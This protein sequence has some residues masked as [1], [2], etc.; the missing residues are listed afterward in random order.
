MTERGIGIAVAKGWL[1]VASRDAARVQ[2][3]ANAAAGVA[4]LVAPVQALAP[5]AVVLEATGGHERLVATA[6]DAADIPVA[7]VNPLRGR[8]FA[9]STGTL[10]KTAA[11]DARMLALLGTRMQ[12]DP[13][14]R[15]DE[16]S[17]ELAAW[18]ARRRQ[19]GDLQS[20]ERNRRSSVAP[21]RRS[22]V[23]AHRAGLA[24]Q[25]AE[26]DRE[27]EQTV[28]EDPATQ[29]KAA[30]VRTIPG[31]G[32]VVAAPLVG[33]V[34]ERGRL[35][36]RQSAALAGVAPRHR[37]S[38]KRQ[39]PRAIWGGRGAVRARLSMAVVGGIPPIPSSTPSLT[40][41]VPR[42]KPRRWRW[43]PAGASC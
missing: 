32:P 40:G 19:L 22:G 27:V 33:Q 38:G 29:A 25:I 35:T 28:R 10:A 23:D 18:L 11:L 1:A 2:R 14:P 42:G 8:H 34:P 6:R 36:R 31:I 24:G 21:R 30:L 13:R 26:L 43:W 39:G 3:G 37:D 5:R 15:P 7:I 12:P 20:A 4:A 41:S 16:P 17:Q 9:R